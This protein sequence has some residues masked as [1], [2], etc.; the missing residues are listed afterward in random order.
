MTF[1]LV[2]A[3]IC[4]SV[5]LGFLLACVPAA[6]LGEPSKSFTVNFGAQQE[7]KTIGELR[8]RVLALEKKAVPDVSIQY[9]MKRYRKLFENA[10]SPE[11]KIEALDR[12]NNLSASYGVVEKDLVVDPYVQAEVILDTYQSIVASGD[13]YHRMDELLYQTAKA[14]SFTGDIL[15]SVKRLE[16]LVALYPRSPL[17]EEA[18]FR[19]AENYFELAMFEKAKENYKKLLKKAKAPK[20]KTFTEYKL[21]WSNYRLERTDDSVESLSKFFDDFPGIYTSYF[22]TNL[23][24]IPRTPTSYRG[25]DIPLEKGLLSDGM[26]LLAILTENG[27]RAENIQRVAQQLGGKDRQRIVLRA[28]VDQLSAKTRYFD[29][30]RLIESYAEVAKPSGELF[31]YYWH[32][33]SLYDKGEHSIEAWKAKKGLVDLFGLKSEFWQ[34][35]N[36]KDRDNIKPHLSTTVAELA[37]LSFLRMQEAK[38]EDKLKLDNARLAAAYYLQL[39]ALKPNTVQSYESVYLAAQ[40]LA[41]SGQF[42]QAVGLYTTAGYSSLDHPSRSDSAY[43]ALYTS[44]RVLGRADG[45]APT[46]VAWKAEQREL[47]ERF[48]SAY[49]THKNAAQVALALAQYFIDWNQVKA[50]MA[51]LEKFDVYT[52]ATGLQQFNAGVSLA[53]LKYNSSTTAQ[54]FLVT[55]QAYRSALALKQQDQTISMSDEEARVIR[56][57]IVN[58]VY[59]QAELSLEKT[60]RIALYQTVYDEFPTH[61]LAPDALFNSASLS[62]Q[63]EQWAQ[64]V[65]LH[66]VFQDA[67]QKHEM[68]A[69]SRQQLIVALVALNETFEAAE[70]LMLQARALNES[71]KTLSANSAF[72]AAQYFKDNGFDSMVSDTYRWMMKAHPSRTDLGIEAMEF[73]VEVAALDQKKHIAAANELIGYVEKQGLSDGRSK[74]LAANSAMF[75]ASI[76]RDAFNKVSLTQPF[77]KSLKAKTKVLDAVSDAYQ[78]V[79]TYGVSEYTNAARYE[80]ATVYQTLAFDIMNSERPNGLSELEQEQ[81]A[82]LLEERAIPIEE[83]AIALHEQNIRRRGASGVDEWIQASYDA[84]ATLNPS[85]YDRPIIGPAYAPVSN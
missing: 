49:P 6:S 66:R 78:K 85:Y 34:A 4:L 12:I 23:D 39:A 84:L 29:A 15:E 21:A 47:A 25:F 16:L 52:N 59:Q 60:Q 46:D 11:V 63:T 3:R 51:T 57:G 33:I 32:A 53:A 22:S 76:E 19:L 42:G 40:A 8:P 82:I 61:G 73:F 75:L 83:E 70:E 27:D 37:H 67:Y 28:L 45:K 1:V 17:A 38:K 30:A 35:A 54:D 5:I 44:Q 62:V 80:M 26:R 68:R 41:V 55:E 48:V 2:K 56:N 50:A 71:D 36:A 77:Q 65:Q 10:K 9:V 7:A 31:D 64:G 14:T 18:L 43:A 79:T 58:S 72:Q 20:L 13:E 24:V 74:T 69:V 81:Y